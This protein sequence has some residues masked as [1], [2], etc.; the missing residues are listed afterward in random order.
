MGQDSMQIG[1]PGPD[2][3]LQDV[4]NNPQLENIQS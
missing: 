1:G 4:M 2:P 3:L